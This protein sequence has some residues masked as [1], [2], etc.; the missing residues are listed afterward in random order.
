[1]APIMEAISDDE[2]ANI[3]EENATCSTKYKSIKAIK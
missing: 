1:M 3:I 2:N